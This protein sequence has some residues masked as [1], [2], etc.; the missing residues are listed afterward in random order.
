MDIP[1]FVM[2]IIERLKTCGY[3]A[4]IVGG[5]V[6]DMC[7]RRPIAD[8]DVATSAPPEKI[9]SIF[10]DAR[11][12][13]LKHDTVTLVD[14]TRLYEVTT[15]RGSE[16]TRQ[17]IEEDLGHRDFTIDAMAYDSER[18]AVLD[19]HGGRSDA[20]QELIRAVGDPKDRFREDPLRL[21]RAVRL[22]TELGF[23]IE[24]RTLAA[25]SMM[26]EQLASVAQER[27]RAE[28]MKILMS[29]RPSAG[30]DLMVRT[31]LLKQ[32]LPELLEGYL[33]RQNAHHRF[34]IYKHIME[35]VDGVELD[36]VL[37]LTALFH[38]IAK[39]RV[40]EKINGKFR[41]LGH[42]EASAKLAREIM[43]R[44][45]FSNKMIGR[46]AHLIAHHMI[47]YDTEWGDGAVRRLIRRVGPENMA[48]LL[49]F[50]R[51]DLLAHG[52]KDQ[53]PD[54]LSELER[55]VEAS[56]KRPQPMSA[57]DLAIDGRRVMEILALTQGPEVGEVLNELLGRVT[58]HPEMNTEERLVDLLGEMKRQR[59]S[60]AVKKER[61]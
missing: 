46:V 44:L 3:Q 54:L 16:R 30:F 32:F 23:K 28:M 15:F 40:R 27:V 49:T 8:W 31:G 58:D 56:M 61:R 11:H 55:R 45:K 20:V 42:E 53:K 47:E 5:A 1:P 21:L 4:Y 51:A 33:K 10:K 18:K 41:F 50:R 48:H 22:A 2:T 36:P 26:A 39:P 12:F 43:D 59:E 9:K 24:E 29:R 57:H 13:S 6:R 38:D 52:V 14:S 7:L 35:T 17:S 25:I 60:H 34:T 37:R 19:P